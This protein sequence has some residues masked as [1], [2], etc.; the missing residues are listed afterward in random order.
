[1]SLLL[2]ALLGLTS[3]ASIDTVGSTGCTAPICVFSNPYLRFGSGLENSVNSW[4]LFVQPWYY[5]RISNT[6][7]KLTFNNYPLD[8]AI[9]VGYGSVHWS[10]ATITDLYTLT[11]SNSVTDY[12]G[13]IVN[14]SDTTKT[15]GYGVIVANR[16]FTISGNRIILQ[17]TFSLGLTD[18]FVKII[19]RLI[20]I[21]DLPIKNAIMWTGT[22]DDYVGMT[23]VNIKIRGNLNTGSF[24]PVTSNT[25]SS[26]AIM[27]KNTE[28]GVLFYSETEGVMTSYALC[29][30]FA[31]AYNT[32]PLS[33]APQTPV[34]TDGSYAAVLPIGNVSIGNSGSITWFY[35][36]GTV[37]SLNTVAQSVAAAQVAD[38]GVIP[39][40]VASESPA[41][42]LTSYI[43]PSSVYSQTAYRTLSSV[44]SQTAYSTPS[45]VYSESSSETP[46]NAI[47]STPSESSSETTTPSN[48]MSSTPSE[49]SSETTTPSNAMSSTP[50]ET[51]SET[52][53]PSN[54]MSS[55]PSETTTPSNAMSFTPSETSSETSSKTPTQTPTQTQT[56]STTSTFPIKVLIAQQPPINISLV[57]TL[58]IKDNNYDQMLYIIGFVPVLSILTCVCCMGVVIAG[59]YYRFRKNKEVTIVKSI[60]KDTIEDK[61]INLEFAKSRWIDSNVKH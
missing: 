33:L 4:G 28:E 24:V 58:I 3:V 13:F 7:Y 12:S 38:S 59:L 19:T 17:N 61:V 40:V 56:S 2:L 53:T 32:Y 27:I 26:R 6:W 9:G 57:E 8:T 54:A 39:I 31:N 14:S 22:R 46:S 50:S 23:D 52:T 44:Y 18:S 10:G 20:N 60:N 21:G 47:S 29:C 55:T 42:T 35:A 48:A 41:L 45:Y 15:V 30:S 25:Q 43:T 34:G 36:A 11:S 16:T 37:S 51:S 1:M 5:S 49:T